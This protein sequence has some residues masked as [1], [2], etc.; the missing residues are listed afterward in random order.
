MRRGPLIILFLLVLVSMLATT[1]TAARQQSMFEAGGELMRDWW[2]RATLLDAYC[3]FITFYVWVFARE[4]AAWSR[5]LWFVLIMTLGN[6]AM[7]IYVLIALWRLPPGAGW[8]QLWRPIRG[9]LT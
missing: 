2:F 5:L 1:I 7:S 4:Q 3:G 8:E 9:G 6:I